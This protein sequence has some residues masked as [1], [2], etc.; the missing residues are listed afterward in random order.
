MGPIATADY[1]GLDTV[2]FICSVLEEGLGSAYKAAPL[3]KRMVDAGYLGVK[4]GK[5]F[6]VYEEGKSITVNP[7]IRRF[8]K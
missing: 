6:Y 4:T 3:L 7:D 1:I 5:G 2:L 8:I